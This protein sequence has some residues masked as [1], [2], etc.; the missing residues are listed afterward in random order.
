MGDIVISAS[1]T[2]EDLKLM[3]LTLPEGD[4]LIVPT[5]DFLRVRL[6]ED[7]HLTTVLKDHKQTL[8]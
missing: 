4:N 3:I 5:I 2:V 6:I 1:D 7:G 8:Q